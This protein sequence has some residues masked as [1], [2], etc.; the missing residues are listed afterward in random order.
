MNDPQALT[1]DSLVSRSDQLMGSRVENELV[2]MDIES[3][4]YYALDPVAAHIWDCLVEPI[5]ISDLCA[6]LRKRY[7]VEE[8]RCQLEVLNLLREIQVKGM[9]NTGG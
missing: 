1:L 4:E 2:M 7:A 3:G 6:L 8:D 5:L 9:L